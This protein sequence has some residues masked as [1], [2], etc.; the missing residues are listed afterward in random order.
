V[1]KCFERFLL[2]IGVLA[3]DVWIWSHAAAVLYD[4]WQERTFDREADEQQQDAEPPSAAT[5]AQPAPRRGMVARLLIPRLKLRAMVREGT[6]EDT[7]S[8]ALG[9][10]PSTAL[11]GEQGNIGIAGH[12]DTIFRGLRDIRKNDVIV[13]QTRAGSYTYRV[14]GTLIVRPNQVSVLKAGSA[15]ELT[16]VTC[17]PFHYIGSAPQRFI[18]KARQ[19]AP[20]KQR[21]RKGW[22]V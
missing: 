1:R 19:V 12:R 20:A 7:L 3:I 15:P 4:S 9:H 8:L 2:L 13:L 11:P 6:G 14:E 21:I 22:R 5:P 16:L 18:V 17:Y 10:I